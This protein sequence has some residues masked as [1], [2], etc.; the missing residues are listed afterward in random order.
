M[1]ASEASF[2]SKSVPRSS[3]VFFHHSS[4]SAQTGGTVA[5]ASG[6]NGAGRGVDRGC[7]PEGGG[8]AHQ[9]C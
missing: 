6:A 3:S 2:V 9:A 7:G 4:A 5:G 8:S 1:S